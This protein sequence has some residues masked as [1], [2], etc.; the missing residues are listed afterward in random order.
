MIRPARFMIAMLLTVGPLACEKPASQSETQADGQD[1]VAAINAVRER[2]ATLAGTNNMD[3]LLTVY[4]S[5]VVFMPPN[6]PIVNGHDALKKWGDA[7]FEQ[8]TINVRYTSS[9]VNVSGDWAIDQY[10]GVFTATPKAGGSPAEEKIK[11]V[12]IM[13]R[14][15]DGTWR[16]AQDVWNADAQAPPSSPPTKR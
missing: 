10:T 7:M 3:S 14:Q 1:A 12:H 11:G 2:E 8:V 5:D 6:E 4:T 9:D 15:S 16:I 13:K